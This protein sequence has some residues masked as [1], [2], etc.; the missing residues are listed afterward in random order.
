MRVLDLDRATLLQSIQAAVEAESA[1][2]VAARQERNEA[3]AAI[4][5]RL[6]AARNEAGLSRIEREMSRGLS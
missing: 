6:E 4:L 2:Q 5:K 1:E 3:L